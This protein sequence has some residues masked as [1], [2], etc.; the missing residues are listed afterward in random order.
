[1]L[2]ISYIPFKWDIFS[3]IF[4]VILGL[5]AVCMLYYSKHRKNQDYRVWIFKNRYLTIWFFAWLIIATLRLVD[6]P[7]GG[8]DATN[9][10]KY[11][12]MCN[13]NYIP[14]YFEH[15]AGDL[16]FKFFNQLIRFLTSDYHIY[17]LI[18]YGLMSYAF[19]SFCQ[20]FCPTTTVFSPYILTFFLYLRG[21]STVRSHLSI[22]II[23]FACILLVRGKNK[24][25]III[26]LLSVLVH[27]AAL[28]YAMVI[29][30]YL[31]FNK[32][33]ISLK[34]FLLLMIVST[35]FA[36][37]LQQYFILFTSDMELSGAYTSYAMRSEDTSFLDNAWKIAFEQLLLGFFIILYHK[38]LKQYICSL[39]EKEQTKVNMIYLICIFD[40]LLIPVNYL[41]SIWRGYEYFYLARLV[42][43]GILLY[44]ITQKTPHN[45]KPFFFFIFM[46]CFAT[47][48]VFRIWSTWESSGLMPYVF[49]P[50]LYL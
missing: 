36:S 18:V 41:L 29:P 1:M 49:E 15:F 22:V 43:W 16:L 44:I 7:I 17:F 9:Y 24:Q 42:M 12:G 47:W 32:K 13:N 21:F 6:Y 39:N 11:F 40:I 25:A 30:F 26:A 14:E 50:F 33:G 5:L 23:I 3:I 31:I 38:K 35:S 2:S 48:M 10:I 4:Y 34:I 46:L 8:T 37:I 20:E 45:L 19:I 27:K 28:L